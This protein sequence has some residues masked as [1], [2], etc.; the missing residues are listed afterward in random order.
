MFA[1]FMVLGLVFFFV[2]I[3]L[4][5]QF[6][7]ILLFIWILISLSPFAS[8]PVSI[9]VKLSSTSYSRAMRFITANRSSTVIVQSSSK[10]PE[11]R[12]Q[13]QSR[14]S[15]LVSK[16]RTFSVLWLYFQ[17]ARNPSI[18]VKTTSRPL[19]STWPPLC[20]PC[21]MC[22]SHFLKLSE[23][24]RISFDTFNLVQKIWFKYLSMDHVDLSCK[25]LM[26]L[27]TL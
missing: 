10:P 12:N 22:E 1:H 21:E 27:N 23:I 11:S 14:N 17:K 7:L 19:M 6:F 15:N 26:N 18:E 24:S 16:R 9:I 2:V 3:I 5:S 20:N 4:I 25:F 8:T 13:T